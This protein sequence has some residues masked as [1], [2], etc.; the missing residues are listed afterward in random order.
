M[1]WEIRRDETSYEI[2][3]SLGKSFENLLCVYN[4]SF[5]YPCSTI[6]L[7]IFEILSSRPP[8]TRLR[9]TIL[10]YVFLRTASLG[11]LYLSN[12][13][14]THPPRRKI[15]TGSLSETLVSSTC[16]YKSRDCNMNVT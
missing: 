11:I 9:S 5:H 2:L 7:Q 12:V 14:P 6:E 15:Q 1:S 4:H 13:R 3:G 8:K 10:A 16:L